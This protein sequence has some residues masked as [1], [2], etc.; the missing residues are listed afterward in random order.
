MIGNGK[1]V[2]K[3]VDLIKRA[4]KYTDLRPKYLKMM[5]NCENSEK[6]Q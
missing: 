6:Y 5:K 1:L 4:R 2:I 3:W